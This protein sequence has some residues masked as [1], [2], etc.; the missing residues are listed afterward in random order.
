MPDAN[1]ELCIRVNQEVFGKANLDLA[2]ELIAEDFVNHAAPPG[3]PA[4][5][6]RG[7]ESVKRTV[8]IHGALS[9]IRYDVEDAFGSGDRVALRVTMHGTHTG[10]LFGRPATGKSFSAQHIHLFHVSDGKIREHWAVR[11]DLGMF[12]QL[13]LIPGH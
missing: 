3:A 7:P 5:A 6:T 11:D 2:D 4:E 12:Q 13:G 9:D 10:D 8:T 1:T